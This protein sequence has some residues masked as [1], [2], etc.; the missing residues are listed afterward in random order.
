MLTND[1]LD[2]GQIDTSL[3]L[4]VL[5]SGL[6]VPTTTFDDGSVAR[7]YLDAVAQVQSIPAPEPSSIALGLLAVAGFGAVVIHK[8]RRM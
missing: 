4:G 8:R 7:I 6:P 1:I 3:N 5:V 2:N